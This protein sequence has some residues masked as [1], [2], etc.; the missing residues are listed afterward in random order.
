MGA[1]HRVQPGCRTF[2]ACTVFRP[3]RDSGARYTGGTNSIVYSR[4]EGVRA[5]VM[6]RKAPIDFSTFPDSDGEDPS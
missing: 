4:T 2:S 6:Y 5:V 1:G 3:I